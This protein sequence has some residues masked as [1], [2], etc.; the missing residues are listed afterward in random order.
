MKRPTSI[1]Q[2]GRCEIRTYKED[3]HELL[4]D[5]EY[6]AAFRQFRSAVAYQL[7]EFP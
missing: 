4:F 7:R 6:V 2:S 1:Y 3:Y 5:G